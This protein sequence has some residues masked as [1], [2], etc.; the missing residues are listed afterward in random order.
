VL[1]E[2][3]ELA[4]SFF[5][6]QKLTFFGCASRLR[7][8]VDLGEI[9]TA[10]RASVSVSR[11]PRDGGATAPSPS[12]LFAIVGTMGSGSSTGNDAT[13]AKGLGIGRIASVFGS[14]I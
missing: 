10:S 9:V 13:T 1:Y 3:V 2:A 8:N 11:L 4:S 14:S 12:K 6:L 7:V 5:D